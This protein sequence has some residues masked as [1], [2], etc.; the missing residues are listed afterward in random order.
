[1]TVPEVLAIVRSHCPQNERDLL[2]CGFTLREIGIGDGSFRRVYLMVGAGLIVKVP[3]D[4]N[5]KRC[6]KHSALEVRAIRRILRSKDPEMEEL[7]KHMP[8]IYFYSPKSGIVIMKRYRTSMAKL[9]H[10]SRQIDQ[11]VKRAFGVEWSDVCAR[12]C[13]VDEDGTVKIIDTGRI[14]GITE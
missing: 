9:F 10:Q 3:Q 5:S 4:W 14:L 13:G 6:I 8:E 1:M 11:K 2:D 7:K 12:N